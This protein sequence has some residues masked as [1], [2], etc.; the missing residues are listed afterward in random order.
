MTALE[1]VK[2]NR[3]G[4]LQFFR[5]KF[6][7]FHLSNVFYLDIK[8]ALKY[9]L[10]ENHFKVADVELETLAETLINEMVL[11][12]L[13]KYISNGTWTLNYPEF[14]AKTPGKPFLQQ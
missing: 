13:F 8:Y 11:D 12:G 5:S 4:F 6:P 2:M 9:Y 3:R 10:V 1:F 7:I 14:R